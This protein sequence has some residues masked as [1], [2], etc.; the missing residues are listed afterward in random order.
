MPKLT[1]KRLTQP[2]KID[3]YLV[4]KDVFCLKDDIFTHLDLDLG[5][6]RPKTTNIGRFRYWT[7]N[8]E[9]FSFDFEI[10]PSL[11]S[12]NYNCDMMHGEIKSWSTSFTTGNGLCSVYFMNEI[13]M[14]ISRIL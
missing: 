6:I 2:K 7:S 1:F 5:K 12:S 3:L 14:K 11:R 9:L 4:S 8:S 13:V 10:R